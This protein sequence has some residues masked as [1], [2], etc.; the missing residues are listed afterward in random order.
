[1]MFKNLSSLA[2][3]VFQFLSILWRNFC[4]FVF[5]FS[6]QKSQPSTSRGELSSALFWSLM[7]PAV[8]WHLETL[9]SLHLPKKNSA[10]VCCI[11]WVITTPCISPI[12]SVWRP[13]SL[14]FRQKFYR[15]VSM[16]ET[17]QARTKEPWQSGKLSLRNR[18]VEVL[19]KTCCL[20]VHAK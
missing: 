3:V 15:T 5:F 13:F 8:F 10:K 7:G 20:F 1:M 12:L 11:W 6:Q 18:A 19:Y 16:S 17:P 4:F 14:S 2:Q 9:L